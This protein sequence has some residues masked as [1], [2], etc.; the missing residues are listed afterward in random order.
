M[1][2]KQIDKMGLVYLIVTL[3]ALGAG[4]AIAE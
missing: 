3:A 1:T 2:P 4:L